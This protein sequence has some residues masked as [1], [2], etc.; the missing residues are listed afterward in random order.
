MRIYPHT[1]LYQQSGERRSAAELLEPAYYTPEGLADQDRERAIR[2]YTRDNPNW[3]LSDHAD[4]N[5]AL[6]TRL[7]KKGKQGPLWEYMAISRRL[8]QD[9]KLEHTSNND[10]N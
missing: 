5:E 6:T 3:F 4:N 10:L 8:R 2:E 1:P 9:L 7:R